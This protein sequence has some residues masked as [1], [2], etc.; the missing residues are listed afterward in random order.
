MF[1]SPKECG[2]EPGIPNVFRFMDGNEVK[3][4]K[5]WQ[6][7]AD[8][9]K[10]MYEYYMYGPLPETIEEKVSYSLGEWTEENQ[11]DVAVRTASLYI[12]VEYNGRDVGFEAVICLPKREKEVLGEKA[13]FPVHLEM[14]FVWEGQELKT[15]QNDYYAAKRGYASI[16]YN[17]TSI[18]EDR[19]GRSGTFYTLHPY[20]NTWT[21]QTGVLAAWGWGASKILDALQQGLAAELGI[22]PAKNILSG[23]SRYGKAT[24][25]AG[26]YDTRFKVVVP[27]CSGAGGAAMYRYRS[28][29]NIYNLE[30]IGYMD[31]VGNS[32]YTVTQNEALSNLQSEAERHWF[33]DTFLE[34]DG[35]NRLPMDQHALVSLMAHP[36]R[37]LFMISAVTQE[38]WVNA[39]SMALTYLEA[40]KVYDFLGITDHIC[41][42]EHLQ[43]HAILRSDMEKLLDY[44]DEVFYSREEVHKQA[45]DLQASVFWTQEG[46]GRCVD[47]K[48]G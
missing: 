32:L 36:E 42:C 3:T 39:A 16:C 29:G 21:E 43:G 19:C 47:T 30:E 8:E 27:A 26:A 25:V 33:N 44:C 45:I 1:K 38:D 15:S 41:L 22:D 13:L 7:R 14:S 23:V 24:L 10:K 40:R 12:E 34:F 5:E 48:R 37:Y 35:E 20:G 18:A 9:L 11:D 6:K 28:E 46:L 31:E 4:V 2:V 17:P